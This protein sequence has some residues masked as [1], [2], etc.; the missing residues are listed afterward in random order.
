MRCSWIGGWRYC[1]FPAYYDIF[2]LIMGRPTIVHW[3]FIISTMFFMIFHWLFKLYG[4]T[5]SYTATLVARNGFQEKKGVPGEKSGRHSNPIYL[6]LK[7]REKIRDDIQ[8]F[9]IILKMF[10]IIFQW[11]FI[12]LKMFF[13]FSL[14]FH[15]FQ[16][17]VHFSHWFFIIF[18]MCFIIAHCFQYF[19]MF[20]IIFHWFFSVLKMFFMI[21]RYLLGRFFAVLHAYSAYLQYMED[22]GRSKIEILEF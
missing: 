22:T 11:F 9:F 4:T 21:F 5:E 14:I 1:I 3:F 12:I 16:D 15:Y 2:L 19:Y 6:V 20:F 10:F 18:K 17:V 8:W 7:P 13:W